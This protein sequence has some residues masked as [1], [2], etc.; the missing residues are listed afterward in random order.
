MSDLIIANKTDFIEVANA[1]REKAGTSDPLAFP[2]GFVN[3]VESISLGNTIIA[4]CVVSVETPTGV[5]YYYNHEQLP[6]IPADA[7][8]NY[9]Y[10]LMMRAPTAIWLCGSK[11]K[12]YCYTFEDVKQRLALPTDNATWWYRENVDAWVINASYAGGTNFGMGGDNVWCVWWSNYDI[13]NGSPDATEIYFPASQPQTGQPT[14][15]T[16]Y[17]YNGVKLPALPTDVTD[18]YWLLLGNKDTGK[19][20][21][22]GTTSVWYF[23]PTDSYPSCVNNAASTC[24]RYTLSEDGLL[25]ELASS[26]SGCYMYVDTTE[27]NRILWTNNNVPNGSATASEVYFYGTL[28]VPNPL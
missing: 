14:G 10:L 5:E 4:A 22:Y 24:R 3:A 26:D 8:E 17:Y 7:A 16:Q 28:A 18:S 25:W 12:P 6:E 27:N 15:A 1:I 9:P 20:T 21:L 13:P 19:A 23:Y 11:T 2:G